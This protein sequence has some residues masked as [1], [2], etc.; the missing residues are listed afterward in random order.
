MKLDSLPNKNAITLAISNGSPK[1]P[2]GM[3]ANHAFVF[4]VPTSC[5]L[6]IA[7]T[8]GVFVTPEHV[9]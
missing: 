1:R 3:L 8:I 9:G 4:S 7:A 6:W 5:S 2:M